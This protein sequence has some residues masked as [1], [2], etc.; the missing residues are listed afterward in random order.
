[1]NSVL[2]DSASVRAA[3]R[4]F[5]PRRSLSSAWQWRPSRPAG[6]VLVIGLVVTAALAPTAVVGAAPILASTPDAARRF[7]ARAT[8]AG[9]L[10]LT[11]IMGSKHA[12]LGFEFS[13]PSR[14]R[15]L[16][17]YAENLLPANRRSALERN[18]AFSDL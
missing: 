4:D 11:P 10:N 9:V 7:F 13:A 15:G 8:R 16:A 5:A 12:T 2:Q 18:S 6:V 17:V 1:M 14:A 3:A